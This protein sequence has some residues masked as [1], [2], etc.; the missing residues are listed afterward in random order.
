MNAGKRN[1]AASVSAR[2][3]NRAKETG[4]D[5]QTLLTNYCFERLLYRVGESELRD[6]F[7]LKGAGQAY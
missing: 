2:L 5:Y 3:L 4:D 6:R 1:L 7:V